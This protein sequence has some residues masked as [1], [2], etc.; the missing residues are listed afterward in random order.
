MEIRD[1]SLS[2]TW[3]MGVEWV[4]LTPLYLPVA[5]PF[6]TFPADKLFVS[7]PIIHPGLFAS[8]PGC[9]FGNFI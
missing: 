7:P 2:G 9:V 3:A 8:C 6:Y 4:G 5:F 1:L